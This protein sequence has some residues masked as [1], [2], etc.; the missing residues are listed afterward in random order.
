MK[1]LLQFQ[2]EFSG[3]L[4]VD[5]LPEKELHHFLTELT[6]FINSTNYESLQFKDKEQVNELL[7]GVKSKISSDK[8]TLVKQEHSFLELELKVP[9]HDENAEE[10]MDQAEE[11]FLAGSYS[12]A[13]KL[14]EQVLK[15]EPSW[16]RAKE[17][18]EQA[19]KFLL[20]GDI[21]SVA[22]PTEAAINYGK[23]QSAVRVGRYPDAKQYYELAKDALTQSGITKWNEGRDFEIK[24]A[25]LIQ[26]EKIVREAVELFHQGKVD[27]AIQ[28]L[29][30]THQE[31]GIPHYKDLADK[32]RNFRDVQLRISTIFFSQVIPPRDQILDAMQ[33]VG[34]LS[35]DFEGVPALYL[36]HSRVDLIKISLISSLKQEILSLRSQAEKAKNT[37]LAYQYAIDAKERINLVINLGKASLMFR[38]AITEMYNILT[39]LD[40]YTQITNPK[41]DISAKMKVRKK[42]TKQ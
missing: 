41:R 8:K 42:K 6:D 39:K 12:N 34:K 26:A 40:R 38:S 20:S 30:N 24:L 13:I 14:Y 1:S 9:Q 7:A 18:R 29:D 37:D 22:L 31:T 33:D 28:A 21:P 23:A 19:R 5:P 15:I 25:G 11:L 2:Q 16:E 36:L 35:G 17:Y 10:L 32:Y 27:D 3:F 4:S